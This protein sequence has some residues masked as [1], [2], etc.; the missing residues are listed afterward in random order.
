MGTEAGKDLKGAEMAGAIAAL[1]GVV[2][3]PAA[4]ARVAKTLARL[5]VAMVPAA[6]DSGAQ[7]ESP[8]LR[9]TAEGDAK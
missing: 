1:S 4:A 2:L 7:V 6:A 9:R 5:A 3:A 8:V